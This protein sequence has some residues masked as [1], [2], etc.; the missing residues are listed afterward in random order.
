[1]SIN[2]IAVESP[3]PPELPSD[4]KALPISLDK[5]VIVDCQFIT[6][7]RSFAR[8]QGWKIKTRRADLSGQS[9]GVWR[10]E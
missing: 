3:I 9:Y 6:A 1:M 5:A 4:L 7:L 10:I 2:N 8:R